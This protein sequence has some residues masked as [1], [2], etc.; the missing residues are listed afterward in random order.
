M[1][2]STSENAR[3]LWNCINKT[4]RRKAS[5]SLPAHDSTNSLYNSFYKHFNDKITQIHASFPVSA[6]SCNIDFPVVHHPCSVFTPALLT[7]VPKLIWSSP[8]KSCELDPIPTFLLK[9]C[10]H[11]LIVPLTKII[12]LS[13]SSWMFPSHFKHVNVILLLKKSSLPV[14]DINSYRPISNISFISKLVEKAI[15]CRLNVYLN[16][17]NLSNVFQSTYKQFHSAV[18]ALLK[19]NNDIATNMDTGKVTALKPLDWSAAFDTIHYSV[20]LDRISNTALTQIRAFLINRF[21][22]IKIRKCFSKAVPLVCGVPQG[23]VLRLLLFTLYTTPLG[24]PIHSH[25][26]DGVL[27]LCS[28]WTSVSMSSLISL[29]V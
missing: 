15:S 14:N 9:Y 18:T 12:N 17:N 8:N 22:S 27:H 24:S 25:K 6:S 13:L 29:P 16:W 4:L 7:E 1:I 23:S 26:L 28:T 5:I 2:S 19:V 10:L 20:L 21:Q 11:R 3:Q